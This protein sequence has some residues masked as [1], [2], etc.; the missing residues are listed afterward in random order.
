ML[1]TRDEALMMTGRDRTAMLKISAS[2][3]EAGAGAG[4]EAEDENP[5]L[6]K[7]DQ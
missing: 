5:V 6:M 4:T 7:K 2:M 1:Y 3:I